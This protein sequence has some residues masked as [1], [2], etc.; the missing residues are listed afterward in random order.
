MK[1]QSNTDK[2]AKAVES[3]HRRFVK[4]ILEA[5]APT[6]ATPGEKMMNEYF[7]KKVLLQDGLRT[8]YLF[9]KV[10]GGEQEAYKKQIL[11]QALNIWTTQIVNS[12]K[13]KKKNRWIHQLMQRTSRCCS[14]PSHPEVSCGDPANSKDQASSW[15]SAKRIGMT[16]AKQ[17]QPLARSATKPSS[18]S[19]SMKSI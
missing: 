2:Y 6:N 10:I 16:S 14:P 7:S 18:T 13:E 8:D 1:A 9:Y 5:T 15:A 11:N 12:R 3:N 19:S 4:I 17:I